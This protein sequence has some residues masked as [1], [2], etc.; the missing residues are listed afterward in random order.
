MAPDAQHHDLQLADPM[1]HPAALPVLVVEDDR[2]T[3]LLLERMIRARGHEVHGCESAEAAAELLRESFFPLIVLDIQLPGM[4]GLEFSRL[5]R[6]QATGKY[7]YILAGTGNNRPDDLRQVLDAGVDD[8]IAKPYHPGLLDIRLAVAEAAVKDIAERRHLEYD[9]AFLAE[10]DPLT[11]LYNRRRL[12]TAIGDAVDVAREGSP[13]ALLYIDLDNFKVVNDSLG[14]DAGDRLLLAVAEI[15]RK[16]VRESDVLVRFGG[17]E[18]VIILSNCSVE[19]ALGIG[20]DLRERIENL[21][22]AES[23]RSFRIGASIGV[24]QIDGLRSVTDIVSLADMACYAAKA[25]GRNRVELHS[26]NDDALAN[27]VADADWS[28]RI[29]DAMSNGKL[30]LYF[31]PIVA[32]AGRAIICHEVLVRLLDHPEVGPVH[33]AAFMTSIQRSGF[34]ARLDRFVITNAVAALA[35][36]DETALSI[37]ISGSSFASDDFGSFVSDILEQNRISPTRVIFELTE[38]EVLANVPRA[39]STMNHLKELGFRFALDDFGAGASSLNYLKSLPLDIIKIDGGFIR[40]LEGD[41]FNM[42]VIRSVH[43]LSA[44]LNI[45]MV[46]EHIETQ[47]VCDILA[48]LGIQYGQGYLIGKPRTHPYRPDELFQNLPRTALDKALSEG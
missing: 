23:G 28:T 32:F 35:A 10:H 18:F 42:A 17:D 5:L 8:Y 43:A 12:P 40:D 27:L 39:V 34:A 48:G 7:F 2:P 19:E 47:S 20:E 33:P 29:K 21:V 31:Q 30:E 22:F 38:S 37:N 15:L 6:Q 4:S 24:T 1:D 13:G 26:E 36:S 14:H 9:L 46:A 41:P 11:K 44:T 3:R 25:R 16:G 45:P